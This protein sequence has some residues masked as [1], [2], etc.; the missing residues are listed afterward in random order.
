MQGVV[1]MKSFT[2]E[3]KKNDS[4]TERTAAVSE[5]RTGEVTSVS[6]IIGL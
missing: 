3:E 6:E 1:E 2:M 5:E 4:H